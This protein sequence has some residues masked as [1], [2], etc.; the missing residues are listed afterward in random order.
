MPTT[1]SPLAFVARKPGD[2]PFLFE[3]GSG[4]GATPVATAPALDSTRPRLTV[5]QA[6]KLKDEKANFGRL[7]YRNAG[8][9]HRDRLP[10]L[11]TG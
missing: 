11:V 5:A 6:S 7:F 10:G 3:S 9:W 2:P 4:N 8:G 1:T